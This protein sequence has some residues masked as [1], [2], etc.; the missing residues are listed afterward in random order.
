MFAA[1]GTRFPQAKATFFP[2][3]KKLDYSEAFP[4]RTT[5]QILAR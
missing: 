3:A 1:V 2:V 4:H 5:A